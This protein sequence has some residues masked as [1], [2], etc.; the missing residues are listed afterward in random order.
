MVKSMTAYGRAEYR[1]NDLL[2]CIEIRSLNNRY[3]DI[4]LKLPKIIQGIESELKSLVGARVSRGRVEIAVQLDSGA[5]ESPV[6][7][8]LNDSLADSYVKIASEL[9]KRYG[10]DGTLRAETLCQMKDVLIVKPL[11]FDI[12]ALKVPIFDA[13]T[14]ALDSFDQMRSA[15]GDAIR[16]DIEM[17]LRTIQNYA[18]QV[19]SRAPEV[20]DAAASRLKENISRLAGDVPVDEWRMAQEVAYFAD[21]MDVTEE[22]VRVGSH[23]A[24]FKAFLDSSEALG[25]RLDF[26][27][28]EMNR[29]V[30]TIGSKASDSLVSS[31]VVEMKAELEKIR[32]QVQNIE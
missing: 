15:E 16:A 21:R 28:Q 9:A 10:L 4:N 30:N 20:V 25:R 17:R 26:L 5:Q 12:E 31:L 24:Q 11:Q 13:M 22:V 6:E 2:L 1:W 8:A 7:L 18:S 23:L 32:E 14:E 27:L 3:R 19:E 29:E